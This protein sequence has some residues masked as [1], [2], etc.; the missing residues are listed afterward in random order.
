MVGCL[1][2]LPGGFG[3]LNLW[4]NLAV[5]CGVFRG[6]GLLQ[7]FCVGWRGIVFCLV[8]LVWVGLHVYCGVVCGG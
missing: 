5:V 7:V 6:F 1:R 2:V 8:A 4:L 3:L